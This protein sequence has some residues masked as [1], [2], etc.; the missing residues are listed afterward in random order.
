M[1]RLR[2]S[3]LITVLIIAIAGFAAVSRMTGTAELGYF[4]LDE[5]RDAFLVR[6][7]LVDHRP[8]L[9]GGVIPGGI[10]VGPLFFYLSAIPY[11]LTNL[12]PIGPAYGA[13]VIG[14][15]GVIGVY[16]IGKKLFGNKVG[17]V[18]MVFSA[19]SILNVIYQ[20]PW[21]PLTFSQLVTLVVYLT[22]FNISNCQKRFDVSKH[23]TRWVMFL[24]G[25]LVVGAQSDPSALSLIPLSVIWLWWNRERIKLGKGNILK[26]I[27]LFLLAHLTWLIFEFRHNFL[28]TRAVINLLTGD[29]T[30][31]FSI[32]GPVAV[33]K[34]LT[35]LLYRLLFITG[36]LD[37]TK[38]IN[39]AETFI[40]QRL[41]GVW[42]LGAV[43]LLLTLETWTILGILGKSLARKIIA[44]HFL[45]SLGGILIYT[46]LFPGYVH[47]WLWQFMFPAF[48]LIFADIL[49][50]LGR[51]KMWMVL[52]ILGVWGI[53][54]IFLFTKL[55]NMA[56]LG[57]KLEIVREARADIIGKPYELQS[58][59]ELR[60]GGWRYL[61]TIGGE[62]PVKSYMDYVYQGWVYPASGMKPE[63][64][65]VINNPADNIP[66][67]YLKEGVDK[68]S[69]D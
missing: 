30:S 65:A 2:D 15:I 51:K 4:M 57:N 68:G 61:F 16:L 50:R 9:V 10:N 56:G 36:P 34:S 47:E 39:P 38:Q 44:I 25:A 8:L 24:A 69:Y 1:K 53:W 48:F 18:A 49:I 7:L 45:I 64:V 21:W 3:R 13:G 55:G 54:Q 46:S 28:S 37:V 58:D 43:F 31:G 52:G 23:R 41:S 59:G 26:G 20:R 27:G 6:R 11:A 66:S 42:W 67:F 60:Y 63:A 35:G 40:S 14:V 33:L 5:E 22:L 12:N 62:A 17:L 19:F 32:G 29:K